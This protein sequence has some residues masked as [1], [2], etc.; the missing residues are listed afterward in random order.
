MYTSVHS[1]DIELKFLEGVSCETLAVS[2][3]CINSVIHTM[4]NIWQHVQLFL[5]YNKLV[6][7]I[8][9]LAYLTV[10]IKKNHCFHQVSPQT[11]MYSFCLLAT[12]SCSKTCY[13]ILKFVPFNFLMFS[14]HDFFSSRLST[15][16]RITDLSYKL[17]NVHVRAVTYANTTICCLINHVCM[18]SMLHYDKTR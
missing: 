9:R 10:N 6:K 2:V 5:G 17:T 15:K 8:F 14:I 3:E 11:I 4:V 16:T 7:T 18:N 12:R 1:L 13:K